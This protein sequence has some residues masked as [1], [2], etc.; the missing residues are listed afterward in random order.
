MDKKYIEKFGL[1]LPKL[2]FGCMRFP[3]KDNKIDFLQA[4]EMI[5]HAISSGLNYFDTAYNYHDEESER[6][7][8][9]VLPE[10]PRE[11]YFLTSKLP[12]WKVEKED[13]AEKLFNEQLEK[14]NTEYFDFYLLHSMGSKRKEIMD[15]FNLY[16]FMLKKKLEGK[17]KHIG[18]SFHDTNELLEEMV[19]QHE[20]DFVQLQI[21]Y[22]DWNE[23]DAKGAYE[24]LEKRNIPCFVME[25]VRGGFLASF[26]QAV[27]KHFKNYDSNKSTASWA[28]RWVASLPNIAIVL[29]GM[30]NL[31]QLNDN[32]ATFTDFK[33]I[34]NDE[35]KVIDRVVED[36]R[37]I[38][39]IPCTACR[40]CMDC[41]HGV[42]IPGNFGVYNDY[43]KTENKFLAIRN[44]NFIGEKNKANN[45][46]NCGECLSKCPQHIN[47][48]EELEKVN[49]EIN[50]L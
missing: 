5:N 29:S 37:K 19:S 8:G 30:S 12:I 38:K 11:S 49:T 48:P 1:E 46:L 33:P 40:Y 17:V 50:S 14:C 43:K 9:K 22:W 20:W 3:V 4:K 39:P 15:K 45:C 31:T 24:I 36:L 10:F 26:A 28:L 23:N 35:L 42:D 25:P 41:P 13:D 18:F 2:G 16:D 27:E 21:N 32:M 34:T 7:L 44:Y 6:F 47:I